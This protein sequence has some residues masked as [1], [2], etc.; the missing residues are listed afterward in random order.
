MLPARGSSTVHRAGGGG[1]LKC[2]EGDAAATAALIP[3]IP[4]LL[5]SEQVPSHVNGEAVEPAGGGA[6]GGGV[7]S[8]D[9]TR[10][11]V[12]GDGVGGDSVTGGGGVDGEA[13]SG[14]V[15]QKKKKKK[16]KKKAAEGDGLG[17]GGGDREEEEGEAQSGEP[18][19][20]PRGMNWWQ[21]WE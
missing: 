5:Q 18:M 14:A 16:K 19:A 6:A 15:A 17:G 7:G 12:P 11:G 21:V 2:G 1:H 4:V 13:N 8:G 3:A 20:A 9:V 10:D